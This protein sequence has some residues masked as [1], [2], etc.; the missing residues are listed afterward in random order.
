M[1]RRGDVAST[2]FMQ[3]CSGGKHFRSGYD[4]FIGWPAS[5]WPAFASGMEEPMRK[6]KIAEAQK[7]LGKV[8]GG[9]IG[10]IVIRRPSEF[11]TQE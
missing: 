2:T 6:T 8:S 7:D 3:Q 11:P 10:K 4:S 9:N 5:T 1:L